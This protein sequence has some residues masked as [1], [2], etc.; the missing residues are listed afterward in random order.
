[1]D[2]AAARSGFHW[3][4]AG[5][6]LAAA[7]LLLPAIAMQFTDEVAWGPGDFVVMGGLL[8]GLGAAIELFFRLPLSGTLRLA[9]VAAAF[10]VFLLVWAELAVGIF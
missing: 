3:R 6:G 10:G 7:L 9:A 5:W 2:A 8:L 1:M 4:L